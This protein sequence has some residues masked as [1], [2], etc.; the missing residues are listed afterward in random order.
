MTY[1]QF[2]SLQ[3]KSVATGQ[4]RLA[5]TS[6]GML[7]QAAP[8]IFEAL[9]QAPDATFLE[10]LLFTYFGASR[11]GTPLVDLPQLLL[12]YVEE[13]LRPEAIEVYVDARGRID[14]P[15]IGWLL[16]EARSRQLVL[17]WEHDTHRYRLEDEGAPVSF[18]FEERLTL[19]GTAIE[20]CR[21]GNPL[22]ED[23]L[24]NS[25]QPRS[26]VHFEE[27]VERYAGQLAE[28]LALIE[29][30]MPEYYRD[31]SSVIRRIVLFRSETL[32]S[33]A[34][35]AAHGIAFL[36]VQEG[37]SVPR[38]VDD[39]VHQCGHVIF[40]AFTVRRRDFVAVDPGSP[41]DAFTH[42]SEDARSVY[43]VLHGAYT[44]HFM[45]RCLRACDEARV[46]SGQPAHELRG[47]LAFIFQRAIL[48]MRNLAA[49]GLFTPEGQAL[50]DT[51]KQHVD[52]VCRDRPE[53]LRDDFSNQPYN[54]SYERFAQLNPPG[55][56][57]HAATAVLQAENIDTP[58]WGR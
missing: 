52:E 16:S 12:G 13:P 54:F 20:L 39:L 23:L 21:Y 25:A 8:D 38:F 46:F 50:Y 55:G 22:L 51:F 48:D 29:R 45:T 3:A 41:I 17:L 32:N 27:G 4:H 53:L 34:A 10:P 31:L 15:N 58:A 36:N 9:S 19:P 5:Q 1:E 18:R 14:L 35:L 43:T 11:A 30:H 57:E 33:C 37:S 47:L 44:E 42:Q 56:P 49:E 6:R 26:P 7:L 28:A 40:N 24:I 2:L